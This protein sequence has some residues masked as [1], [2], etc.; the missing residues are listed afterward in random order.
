MFVLWLVV[1]GVGGSM[2]VDEVVFCMDEVFQGS[3]LWVIEYIV[4]GVG[5]YYYVVVCQIGRCEVGG[6]F[7]VVDLYVFGGGDVLQYGY[8]GRDGIVVVFCC[9]GE[10]QCVFWWWYCLCGRCGYQGQQ[11]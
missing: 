2:Q 1:F 7:V 5:K 11:K 6:I 8:G 4:G 3:L 10:N 9:M